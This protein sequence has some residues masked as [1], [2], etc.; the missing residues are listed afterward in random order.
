MAV[1][2]GR[3]RLSLNPTDGS[4]WTAGYIFVPGAGDTAALFRISADNQVL[5]NRTFGSGNAL[6]TDL[7]VDP[8]SGNCWCILQ[9]DHD[10]VLLL[11]PSDG[12]QV[13][14]INVPWAGSLSLNPT[15]GSLWTAVPPS[16]I[17]HLS[18]TGTVVAQDSGLLLPEQIVMNPTDGG[19]WIA[20]GQEPSGSSPS[21]PPW[22]AR[23]DAGGHQL[24]QSALPHQAADLDLDA[25]DASVWVVLGGSSEVPPVVAHF[26]ADGTQL[27]SLGDYHDKV[28][29]TLALDPRDRSLWIASTPNV[30]IAGGQLDHYSSDGTLLHTYG[31][32]WD[33]F[34]L[35]I[36]PD[37]SL[38]SVAIQPGGSTSSQTVA[39]V[40]TDGTLTAFDS[41]VVGVQNVAVNQ[42]DGSVW[43][44][45][46][47]GTI[48][49]ISHLDATGQLLCQTPGTFP[50]GGLLAVDSRTGNCW[51]FGGNEV[52]IDPEVAF[53][54]M[55]L[56]DGQLVCGVHMP[57]NVISPTGQVLDTLGK[58]DLGESVPMAITVDPTNGNAWIL[59][60]WCGYRII[61]A[62]PFSD[63]AAGYWAT[64]S[65]L[66][67][68]NA[69]IVAGYTNGTYQP[70]VSV[71]RDQMAA[72]IARALAGGDAKVPDYTG[73]PHF[74]DVPA[75]NWALKYVEYAYTEN[76]VQGYA[77]GSY[78]PA[79]QLNRGQDGRLHRP[80]AG[81]PRRRRGDTRADGLTHV[82][83]RF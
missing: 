3:P 83:R 38:W 4:V 70:T 7:A 52:W 28:L 54:P 63:V 53:G 21:T 39:H 42:Q 58:A 81:R 18:A 33:L 75:D 68:V 10:H 44:F 32:S 36:A 59:D 11:S 6:P 29:L 35:R 25:A 34:G 56:I 16:G 27:P 77:D 64:P 67:C 1:P 9:T 51:T 30:G 60:M 57:V 71:T 65:I 43:V 79:G 22:I 49:C 2:D 61:S 15:D 19:Y 40:T 24:W 50:W 17:A 62:A 12:S 69:G 37:G 78:A 45:D 20:G 41:L 66:A 23:F 26:A 74:T 80:R 31:L 82:L 47:D 73:T 14:Q 76:V 48:P 55:M 8:S 72:Y 5:W 46:N 13:S